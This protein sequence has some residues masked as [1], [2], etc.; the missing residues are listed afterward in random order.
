MNSYKEYIEGIV[1]LVEQAQKIPLGG[2]A[3]LKR[4][5]HAPNAPSVLVFSPHPDDECGT[6]AI[7]LRLLQERG[8]RVKNVVV[9]QGSS[10]ERQA[11]RLKEVT[12]ACNYLGFGIIQTGPVGLLNVR[13]S[14]RD[15][16]PGEWA[17][18]VAVIRD[19][20]VREKPSVIMMPHSK[21]WNSG[22]IGT[23][24]LVEDA[25]ASM[26]KDYSV[27]VVE[28]EF[29]GE[30]ENPNLMI[31]VSSED[32]TRMITGFSFH[33]GEVARNPYH[34]NLPAY[35]QRNV[36]RGAEVV[37]GQGGDAPQFTFAMIYRLSKYQNGVFNQA[38]NR[39]IPAQ[40]KICLDM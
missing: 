39:I 18:K 21:D 36:T 15:G 24:Y 17:E 34:L 33:Y 23:Q 28:T 8:M 13:L 22:H 14:V 16:K 10:P 37:G 20:L 38:P 6:G 7:A 3:P 11:P 29:W 31:E 30:L 1:K 32:L 25:L 2:V 19:I 26:P 5:P 40:E 4:E 12:D 27:T 9:T 35:M